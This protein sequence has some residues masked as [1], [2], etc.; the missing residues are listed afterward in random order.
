MRGT[1]TLSLSLSLLL[2][3]R[4]LLLSSSFAR[5]HREATEKNGS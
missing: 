2:V 5:A 4:F 3:L 1:L